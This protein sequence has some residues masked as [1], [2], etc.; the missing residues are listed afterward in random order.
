MKQQIECKICK[1]LFVPKSIKAIVCSEVCRQ[2]YKRDY[3][4][5]RYANMKE[6]RNKKK[7][8]IK[9]KQCGEKFQQAYKK[10]FCS[11]TCRKIYRPPV[12]PKK[13]KKYELTHVWKVNH[14]YR[15]YKVESRYELQ[16]QKIIEKQE[17]NDA[18]NRYL[19]NGGKIKKLEEIPA[20]A[21]PSVGSREWEWE[22]RVGLGFVGSDS[23]ADQNYIDVEMLEYLVSKR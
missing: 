22:T 8:L 16:L 19:E 10:V 5:D 23:V 3:S 13:P 4:Y 6:A 15:M 12:Q 21:L 17:L 9:C 1:N 7:G 11:H 2:K 18:V 20:P 14:P